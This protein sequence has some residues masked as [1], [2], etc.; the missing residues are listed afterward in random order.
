M[1]PDKP[2][3]TTSHRVL[4]FLILLFALTAGAFALTL[5]MPN[6]PLTSLLIMWTPALAAFVTSLLTGRS[7]KEMGWSVRPVKW[8]A[9]GWL[10]PIAYAALAYIP[11]WLTGLGGVPNPTFLERARLTLNMPAGSD[12][13]VILAAFGFITIINLIPG[14]IMSLGEEIGW[15]GFL[16]PEL[17]KSGNLGKAGLYSGIIWAIW[18]LPG[19]LSGDYGAAD[20]PLAFRLFCFAVLVISGGIIFAWLRIKS[21]SL[22]PAVI[23]HA[24]HNNVIQ[25]FFDRITANTGY[26]SYFAGEFG[27]AL[28]VV[29][30]L[31]ALICWRQL[32]KDHLVDNRILS[33]KS[34]S[35]A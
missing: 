26:T 23:L 7:L 5:H 16:V 25:A 32:T 2:Q 20:T 30:L 28:A 33:T 34:F 9:I 4:L 17:A 6:T 21:G 35:Q 14:M 19:I 10:I 3:P 18:H 29:N 13:T 12:L 11:L 24:A 1:Q 27:F 31:L 15:R 22:W 8:L